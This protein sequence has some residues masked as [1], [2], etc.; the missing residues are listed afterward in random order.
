MKKLIVVILFALCS[1]AFAEPTKID[2][3]G[4]KSKVDPS[5]LQ[6]EASLA[7][8]MALVGGAGTVY[9]LSASNEGSLEGGGVALLFI[10]VPSICLLVGGLATLIEVAHRSGGGNV[11]VPETGEQQVKVDFVPL[12]NPL[13]KTVGMDLTLRF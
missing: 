7:A 13:A 2:T 1:A 10:T 8:L 11:N 9:S 3:V 4:N 6:D 5:D 12:I